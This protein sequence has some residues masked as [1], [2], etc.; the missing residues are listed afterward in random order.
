MEC[1]DVSIVCQPETSAKEPQNLPDSSHVVK[2]CVDNLLDNVDVNQLIN[3]SSSVTD[4]DDK[5]KQT[6]HHHQIIDSDDEYGLS[7]QSCAKLNPPDKDIAS[8]STKKLP[9]I[10]LVSYQSTDESESSS[11]SED[12]SDDDTNILA[13]SSGDEMDA[14]VIADDRKTGQ[15][16]NT[17]SLLSDYYAE[18]RIDY[19]E[20]TL[21]ET[22]VLTQV[23]HVSYILEEQ[24]AVIKTDQNVPPLNLDSCLFLAN[25]KL[26][27]KVYE[28][29]GPVKLPYYLVGIEKGAASCKDKVFYTSQTPEY[30]QYALTKN[31]MKM[32]GSDA[33]WLG[34]VE[35][36]EHCLDYSD[37]EQERQVK[38]DR[39]EARKALAAEADGVLP[40]SSSGNNKRKHGGKKAQQSWTNRSQV[41]N[42]SNTSAS[43][44][45][46]EEGWVNAL[47]N[48]PGR[49]PRNGHNR[50]QHR[51]PSHNSG[52][53]AYNLGMVPPPNRNGGMVGAPGAFI[54]PPMFNHAAISQSLFNPNIPPPPPSID[55]LFYGHSSEPPPP[56]PGED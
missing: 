44:N 31:L 10:D 53:N 50:Q 28:I 33:S 34:D 30:F 46:C 7:F 26:L 42:N 21:P 43:Y 4:V 24:L 2:S 18:L 9:I 16:N 1:E 36:P 38:R 5:T 19:V 45:Q 12:E 23:G 41:Y 49:R 32:K 37:D 6:D 8:T 17:D 20:L 52:M 22:V 47:S 51:P 55:Q 39:K 48:M 15:K 11:S 13:F 56:P 35:P 3:N 40:S 27:G 54:Q 14:A 29:F 25:R